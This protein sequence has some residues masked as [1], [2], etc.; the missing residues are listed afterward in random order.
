M[1]KKILSL[2]TVLVLCSGASY[3]DQEQ[4][5]FFASDALIEALQNNVDDEQKRVEAATKY[6]ELMNQQTGMV[7]I[8]NLFAVCRAAGFNTYKKDGFDSCKQLINTLVELDEDTLTGFCPGLDANGNNPNGLKSITDKTRIGDFCSSTNIYAGEVVFKKGYNC[9]CLSY[10]CNDGYEFKGGSCVTIVADGQG[11]CLR[12]DNKIQKDMKVEEAKAFCENLANKNKCKYKSAVI[13]HKELRILCNATREEIDNAKQI[14]ADHKVK[15]ISAIKYYEV[16]GKDKGKTG[17]KEY[18]VE[19]FFNWTQTQPDQAIGFA[20]E[21]ARIKNNHTVYCKNQHRESGND[22]YIACSTMDGSAVYEFKFDDIKESVDKDRRRTERSALCRLAGG[23]VGFFDA[24]NDVCKNLN[25]AQCANLDKLA[26]K[27]G[28]EAKWDKNKC[29]FTDYGH[30]TMSGEDFDKSLAK[31]DGLDNYAFFNIQVISIR[32]NFALEEEM[33]KYIKNNLSGYQE[34]RCDPGYRTIKKADGFLAKVVGNHDDIK[35]CYANDKPIDFVVDDL[36][37]L[38]GYERD[39]GESG[40]KCI[41]NDG[42]FDG[43]YCRGLTKDECFELER[44]MLKEL[45][46]RGWAGDDDLVDWDERAGACE[47]NA[48][49]FANNL[50]KTGKYT[51]IAGLTIAGVFTGGTTTAVAVSLMSVE[52]AGMAG[53]IVTERQK[54]LLP[55][56]WA[57]RFLAE[58][59][60]CKQASCAEKTLRENM[61]KIAQASDMLNRDVLKQVDDELAR[62]AELLPDDR[63][64]EILQNPKAPGCWET[65]ECQETIFTV[66]QMASLGAAV[67]KALVKLPQVLSKRFAAVAAKNATNGAAHA[68]AVTNAVT[69]AIDN[70]ADAATKVASKADDVVDAVWDATA[71][72]FRDPKTGRFVSGYTKWTDEL[73]EIGVKESVV[74][75]KKVYT[76]VKTG[77]ALSETQVLNKI[78]TSMNDD[79]AKIGVRQIEQADGTVRYLDITPGGGNKFISEAEVLKRIDDMPVEAAK[80]IDNTADAARSASKADDAAHASK[81]VGKADDAVDTARGVSNTANNTADVARTANKA[82]DLSVITKKVSDNYDDMIN[83]I[84]S[85]RNDVM[86]VPKSNLSESEWKILQESLRKEGLEMIDVPGNSASYGI[87]QVM[88][89]K[90]GTEIDGLVFGGA[91]TAGKTNATT[92]AARAADKAVDATRAAKINAARQAD[93]LG[94]HGTDADIAMTD[95]I[96][97][98]GNTSDALGSVGYGIAKNYDDAEKYAIRR[99][100]ERQNSDKFINFK[101]K[102]GVL[103]ITAGEPLNLSNKTGYVYTTAKESNIAWE[104]LRFSHNPPDVTSPAAKMPNAVEILDKTVFNLDDLIRAGK[105]KINIIH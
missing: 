52:L 2:F 55:Q 53:E 61:G 87:E 3:M 37:E 89:A 56:R 96:R 64:A 15:Q 17:K 36:S 4:K 80:A 98:S 74:N 9:T 34:V 13:L 66:M 105:V 68:G 88:I 71:K 94:F 95:K 27:Y 8:D 90:R 79:F 103:E 24:S 50:N 92:D 48:S 78:P 1:I 65:W 33:K 39:S 49:Q 45:K 70:T 7:S 101:V 47:L 83:A 99:L 41:A 30:E 14:M 104:G 84:K 44:L 28:H 62:L 75:G 69:K 43:H 19:D 81:A 12:S 72:R 73:A 63:L 40:A 35:R 59:M 102:N 29:R 77:A 10:A 76:D 51:A 18:C 85:G 82:D 21:Y 20:Q 6:S 22:D 67:G 5:Y 26:K 86:Y 31:I 38:V 60:V 32:N 42:K 100:I 11:F 93:N 25:T 57:N 46:S 23:D 97:P 91:R 16:C 54:E 58:S